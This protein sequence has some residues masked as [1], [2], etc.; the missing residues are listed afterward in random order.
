MAVNCLLA[1]L[2]SEVLSGLMVIDTSMASG[3]VRVATVEQAAEAGQTGFAVV[4]W[5][6]VGPDGES[7]LAESA[8]TI[9]CLQRPDGSLAESD[10]EPDLVAVCGRAY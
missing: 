2:T 1:P 4:P 5:S 7:Q 6:A 8:V 3:T 9:R 10:D